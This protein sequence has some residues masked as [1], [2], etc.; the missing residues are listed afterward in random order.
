MK[1]KYLNEVRLRLQSEKTG[2]PEI[3]TE[4]DMQ[5][6]PEPVKKYIH[7]AGFMGKEKISNVFLKA[8][9][10]FVH[11]KSRAGCSLPLNSTIFLTILS[12]HFISMQ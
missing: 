8:M 4:N 12:V 2:T 3:L 10:K 11:P 9:D 5:H 7:Y 6:L 1:K